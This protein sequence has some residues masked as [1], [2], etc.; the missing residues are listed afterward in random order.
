MYWKLGQKFILI[1]SVFI[2]SAAVWAQG[3]FNISCINQF[4]HNWNAGVN[5]MAVR[6]NYAYLACQQDGLRIVDIT[7]HDS[8]FDVAFLPLSRAD[9]VALAG[10]YAYIGSWAGGVQIID[11]SNPTSPL[12]AQSIPIEGGISAIHTDGDYAFVCSQDGLAFV[13]ISNPLD[14][15]IV[16]SST[17]LHGVND[18]EIHGSVAYVATNYDGLLVMDISDITSPQ[19]TNTFQGVT[20]WITGCSISDG[21]AY[22]SCGKA[23]PSSP[24]PLGPSDK[25]PG[26][27][28]LFPLGR[29]CL[30]P[31]ATRGRRIVHPSY[32]A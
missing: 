20:D 4:Y 6:G 10:N 2:A 7:N 23:A 1:A 21:Y 18:I 19:I 31:D 3:Q 8:P 27:R 29:P 30:T 24:V 26:G 11:I 12:V 22:L 15:Q 17:D 13:D 28:S 9:V 14:A 16:W 5:D 32:C 25:S